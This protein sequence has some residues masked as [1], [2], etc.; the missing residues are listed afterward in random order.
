MIKISRKIM[1][2]FFTVGNMFAGFMSVI[3]SLYLHDYVMAAWMVLVS[4]FMDSLDGKVARLANASSQFGVE[5]DSLADNVSFGLAPSVLIYGFFFHHWGNVGIFISFFPLLFVSIRLA[6]FNVKLEGFDKSEFE[7]LP[8]PAGALLL[9]S[10]VLFLDRYFPGQEFPRVLLVLTLA[11]SVLMVSTIRYDV[12]PVLTFRGGP[13][14][15]ILFVVAIFVVI[16]GILFPKTLLFPYF[17]FYLLSGLARF[18]FRLG[19]GKGL[20][21]R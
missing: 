8:S 4:A 16:F 11:V 7:G 14:K 20:R 3:F 21:K 19:Q 10:Y 9:A 6:R 2:N 13:L 12:L 1:P 18:I 17:L 5:Y 15:A